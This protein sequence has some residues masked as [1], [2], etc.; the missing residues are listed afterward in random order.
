MVVFVLSQ[1]ASHV[2]NAAAP[3]VNPPQ[4]TVGRLFLLQ[5]P[6]VYIQYILLYRPFCHWM[7]L[8]TLGHDQ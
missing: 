8:M 3:T 1:A 2:A 5:V 6:S 7:V 4:S